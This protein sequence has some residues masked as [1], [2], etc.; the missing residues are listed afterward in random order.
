MEKVD[1]IIDLGNSNTRVSYSFKGLLG[2]DIKKYLL[3]NNYFGVYANDD[4]ANSTTYNKDNSTFFEWEGLFIG[5]GDIAS[6]ESRTLLRP[7]ALEL[8]AKTLTTD[9]SLVTVL[10]QVATSI[11]KT[12]KQEVKSVVDNT[13]FMLYVLVPPRQVESSKAVFEEKYKKKLSVNF[14]IP[15]GIFTFDIGGVEVLPEGS[16]AFIG[17]VINPTDLKPVVKYKSL[18]TSKLLVLDI[19]AG[20][21]DILLVDRGTMVES[22][23]AT[24]NLGG[25]NVVAKVRADLNV[26]YNLDLSEQLVG[27][28]C[29]SGLCKVGSKPLNC[30][31]QINS[32]R[33]EIAASLVAE[34][35]SFLESSGIRMSELEY[36]LVVGGGSI[37]D[38]TNA[39]LK[40]IA[41][42]ITE[43]L[44]EYSFGLSL[45]DLSNFSE[46]LEYDD[47][48]NVVE[49]ER[50]PLTPRTLNIMGATT[51][52]ALDK[53]KK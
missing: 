29:K 51:K 30:T 27:E 44:Q 1:V 24:I 17:V 5:H 26:E 47:K 45:V 42:Y 46:H 34:V 52:V 12:L 3:L 11:A 48:G 33:K 40:P 38:S 41:D 8:K 18:L 10:M 16:M 28:A 39:D 50:L 13:Q 31:E 21:T 36:L 2:E 32:A 6:K 22:S 37:N 19:G 15:K 9:Y 23:K 53:L 4:L 20:T 25:N 43:K 14:T 35:K 7:T 49:Y